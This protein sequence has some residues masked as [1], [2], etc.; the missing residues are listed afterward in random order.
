MKYYTVIEYG[1]FE[2]HKMNT[3]DAHWI[4]KRILA[5]AGVRRLPP[6]VSIRIKPRSPTHEVVRT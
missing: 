4:A 2:H 5:T 6:Y 1:S 3:V